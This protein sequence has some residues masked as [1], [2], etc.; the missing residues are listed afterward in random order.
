M[1]GSEN[2]VDADERKS[3]ILELEAVSQRL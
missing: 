3:E 1:P 2:T